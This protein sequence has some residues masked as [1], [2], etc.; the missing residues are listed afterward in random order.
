VARTATVGTSEE[1]A[2]AS[3]RIGERE[4]EAGAEEDDEEEMVDEAPPPG[5]SDALKG[6]AVAVARGGSAAA[7]PVNRT[8]VGTSLEEPRKKPPNIDEIADCTVCVV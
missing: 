1:V 7:P 8:A 6:T 2:A 4:P 3:S 5:V